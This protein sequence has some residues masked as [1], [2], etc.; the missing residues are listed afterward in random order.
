MIFRKVNLNPSQ[1]RTNDCVIRAIAKATGLGWE[2]VFSQLCNIALVKHLMPNDP[3]VYEHFFDLNG[4]VKMK[5][6]R[7]E[8]GKKY[9]VREFLDSLY[10]SENPCIITV[11][12]HMTF[13]YHDKQE[14]QG[15]LFDTWNCSHKCVCNYYVK[16]K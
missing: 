9:T 8:N 4:F 7:K 5:Q 1:K 2:D 16:E 14:H 6:P 12:R 3:K 10:T 15:I 11:A 13:G